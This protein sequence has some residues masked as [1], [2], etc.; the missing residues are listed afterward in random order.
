MEPQF[1]GERNS[2]YGP[3]GAVPAAP[4]AEVAEMTGL[5]RTGARAGLG[6][7]A[8]VALIGGGT[9]RA[10]SQQGNLALAKWKIM[11]HCTKVAQT[12]FPDYTAES[13]ARRDAR[14]KKCLA[15]SNLPPRAPLSPPIP[16]KPNG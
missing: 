7:A 4:I 9:A 6:A 5:F 3:G 8:I 16:G 14:L 10:N 11:D 12:A 15:D 1:G 13:N 2:R